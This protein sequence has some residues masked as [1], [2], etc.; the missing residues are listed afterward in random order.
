MPETERQKVNTKKWKLWPRYLVAALVG[1]ILTGCGSAPLRGGKST[2]VTKPGA[3]VV[4]QTIVQSENPAAVSKQTQE[5][6]KT[7]TYTVPAGS[8]IEE[9]HIVA[10]PVAGAPP[11]TNASALIVSAPMAVVEHDETRAGTELGAAQKDTARE[12]GAKLASLRGI[13]W[14]GV[15]LFIL[16]L[17][18][19][20]YPP[21][22]LIV[23][24][25]TTS[26]AMIGGGLA[27]MVL[28]SMIVGNELLIMGCVLGVVA[29]WFFAYRHGN[30]RGLVASLPGSAS[31]DAAPASPVA[32]AAPSP[33][34]GPP[35]DLG[36]NRPT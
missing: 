1:L 36:W 33:T 6:L 29:I 35:R 4:E 27:L 21:L 15:V 11:V 9:T 13:V 2:T 26:C 17:A 22:K 19:L 10:G 3:G 24:S 5:T 32:A 30:L 23:G 25:V 12:L 8:R 16:G 34:A 14:V 20:F 31:S 7:K 18:T 28:P